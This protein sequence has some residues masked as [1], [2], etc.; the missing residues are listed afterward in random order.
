MTDLRT[1]LLWLDE[2]D[3]SPDAES[4]VLSDSQVLPVT[5]LAVGEDA[6]LVSSPVWSEP[7]PTPLKYGAVY[8]RLLASYS[9][10]GRL[11]WT[12]HVTY[13][14]RG[15]YVVDGTKAV[16]FLFL[17][18]QIQLKETHRERQEKREEQ[19]RQLTQEIETAWQQSR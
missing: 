6:W 1:V 9:G 5:D 12:D 18:E 16:F 15:S 14:Y 2:Q 11:K 8:D 4:W 3:I 7:T 19:A 13:I 17:P 10:G